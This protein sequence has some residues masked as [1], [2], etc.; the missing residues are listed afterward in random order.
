MTN[1]EIIQERKNK[2]FNYFK[3]NYSLISYLILAFIV[4]TTVKIRTRNLPLLKDIT[5]GTWT[6]GPDL[7]PF[8]FLRWAKYIVENSSLYAID[9]L[10]YVPFGYNTSNELL[11]HPYLIAWFHKLA[12]LFGSE[13]ITHSAV[14]Y[15]VFM[16]ALTIIAFFFFVKRIFIISLGVKIA[17]LIGLLAAF[18]L[19]IIPIILPRTIAGI[20]EKESVA[21]L[22]LFL[23]FFFF[24]YSWESEKNNLRYILAVLAGISTA[25]MA[26]V[27]GGYAFIFLT[28]SPAV[29][30]AFLLGKI[31]KPR[32]YTLII[33]MITSAALM[34]PFS[35]RY[36][37]LGYL[38]SPQVT[39]QAVFVFFVIIIH[40]LISKTKLKEKI[41]SSSLRKIPL[42]L[43]STG[44]TIILSA[45]F[46]FIILGPSFIPEQANSIISDLVRPA[47]TSRLIQTVAENRPPFFT[48][49][50]TSFGPSIRNIQIFFWLFFIGSIYLFNS[51]ISSFAKKERIILTCAYIFF[52]SALIFSRYDGN[53]T[54]NGTNFPSLSLFSLGFIVMI[55]AAGFYYFKYYKEQKEHELKQIEFS[56]LLLIVFFLLS[57]V[58]ARG[59]VRLIMLLAIPA[60]IIVSFFCVDLVS[61]VIKDKGKK[62]FPLIIAIIL[63]LATSYSAYAFYSISNSEAAVYAPNTY[64]QQW[65]K[66]MAWV[67]E[68]TLPDSVFAHWWDYG[69][70]LQSIGERATILDG[71]NAISYWNHLMGRYILTGTDNSKALEFLYTHKATHLLIDSTDI[72]KYSAFS[73]IGSNENFDRASYIPTIIKDTKQ[74]RES[75]DS[76]LLIYPAGIGLDSDIVYEI[77]GTRIFLPGG[78]AALIAVIIEKD[79]SNK[80]INAPLAIYTY[81]GKQFEIPL[82]YAYENSLIDFNS[83]LEAGVFIYPLA[84]QSSSGVNLD[85]DGAMLYLSGRTINSRLARF[86]LFNE[87]NNNFK[88]VHS[89]DDELVSQLKLFS[90]EITSDFVYYNGLRGPIKIWKI[91]YPSDIKEN[92]EFLQKTYPKELE[93]A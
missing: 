89:E 63:L 88:L 3:R 31:D 29:F 70:W 47:S 52:L 79:H 27:W 78:K 56:Y 44:I 4:Y 82:R 92:S 25:G 66:A 42:P 30:I 48:E 6:L 8:L 34:I 7:D 15:P 22:F 67:R 91:N 71:G 5:T 2:V 50:S 60:V 37:I 46:A 32:I 20:P 86:Y 35:N 40:L 57:I 24:L 41:N 54:F 59:A 58:A 16:F 43:V 9:T 39:G 84:S 80:I 62:I 64:S 68:N 10:R 77:N 87:E 28:I 26:L 36:T 83:G 81:Q 17:N 90:K 13:S 76:I 53:S 49:W 55:G 1:E 74:S 33:W 93:Q 45:I 19:S 51:M 12:V 14:L 69:Y 65:Q 75:K 38:S 73:L 23:F 85:K 11:L 72:G 18:F 61:K 21:F